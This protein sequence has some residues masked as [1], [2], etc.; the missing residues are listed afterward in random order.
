MSRK[1]TGLLIVMGLLQG[2]FAWAANAD[3]GKAASAVCAACHGAKGISATGAFPNLAGQ[4][5]DYLAAQLKAFRAKTR[6]NPVMAPMAAS[7]KDED[8]DNLAAYY[9]SLKACE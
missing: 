4:K 3:A 5:A 2:N 8:I 6:V 1:F 9:A 7:L